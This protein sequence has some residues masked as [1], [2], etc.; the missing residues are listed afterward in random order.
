MNDR[1]IR[2]LLLAIAIGL[3]VNFLGF[4]I[5]ASAQ[6]SQGYTLQSVYSRLLAI[7]SD[8]AEL[9]REVDEMRNNLVEIQT[10]RC[11]NPKIC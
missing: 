3:W 10:G 5:P 8:L 2:I 9:K 1:A 6:P 11:T 4:L 7:Q